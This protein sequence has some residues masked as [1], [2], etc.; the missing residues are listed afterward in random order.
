MLFLEILEFL[1]KIVAVLPFFPYII[2]RGQKILRSISNKAR[3]PGGFIMQINEKELAKRLKKGNAAALSE[4]IKRFTAYVRTVIRNFAR[5]SIPEQDIDDIC[6]EVFYSLWQYREKLDLKV[7]F[8]SYLS[9]IVRNAVKDVFRN[10]KPSCEDIS[11]LELTSGFSVEDRAEISEMLRCIDERLSELNEKEREM[12]VRFY[13]YGEST[14]EIAQRLDISE[15][16]VRSYLSRTRNKL[17][18]YLMKRGFDH[19]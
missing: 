14:A 12:F 11:E 17:K 8:R 6:V 9:A 7:G 4:I 2:M 16:S 18:E 5:G 13:F 10:A 19:A 15:N 1:Q 3:Q